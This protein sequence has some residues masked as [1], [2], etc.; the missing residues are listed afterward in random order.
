[1]LIDLVQ[2]TYV[3]RIRDWQSVSNPA[4]PYTLYIT[5]VQYSTKI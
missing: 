2:K 1:V 4:A 3:S 5:F